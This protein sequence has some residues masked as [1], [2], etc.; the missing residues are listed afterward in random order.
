MTFRAAR[1]VI[2]R[3]VAARAFPAA[4]IE[5]GNAHEVLWQEAFG[6]LTYDV[7]ATAAACDTVFDL[8]SLTKVLATTPV[9][10][11]QVER[12]VLALD[13]PVA[14]SV[15]GWCGEERAAVT[16]RDLLVHSSGLPAW[17]PYY[18]R[19]EG[20]AAFEAAICAEALEYTPRSKSQ[21][22]DLGFMLLGF[23]LA[24][25]GEGLPERFA[26][27]ARQM[28]LADEMQFNPPALWRA[29]IAPTE[30]DPWRG[31]VLVG[32]VHD[33]NAWALGGAGG[34]AGLFGTAAAV[35]TFARH[36][37]Q[38]L[39]GRIGTV[40]RQTLELFVA[41]D[42][43]VPGSSRALGWDTMRPTSSC[44]SALSVRA[45]GHTGFTGTSL[46]IDPARNLYVVLLTNRV[47]P[48]RMN[49]AIRAVR[50]AFHDA[51]VADLA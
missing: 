2:E 30:R 20:E 43:T 49:D 24:R 19:L 1:A 11:Q 25:A 13:D 36:T 27:F 5:V 44:G 21:Y 9:V 47:H 10:M 15:P 17:R 39:S 35:G 16:L 50:P 26:A 42:V 7:G 48:T 8:A 51:V 33:E 29:R 4:S 31:R 6:H 14:A 28:G 23:I 40:T 46:W 3:A 12:G 22:S 34:H 41:P 32:E 37:L 38:I 45:F 18:R